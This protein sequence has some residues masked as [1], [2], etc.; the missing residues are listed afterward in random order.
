[1][2]EAPVSTTCSTGTPARSTLLSIQGVRCVVDAKT[3]DKD[4]NDREPLAAALPGSALQLV[5]YA[6]AEKGTS[7]AVMRTPT[8]R[9]YYV[10]DEAL[11]YEPLPAVDG[12]LALAIGAHLL[13]ARAGGHG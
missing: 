1:M 2:A 5:A 6:R 8:R 3:T 11:G 13:P 12:A 7:P 9:R 10:Y 4:P